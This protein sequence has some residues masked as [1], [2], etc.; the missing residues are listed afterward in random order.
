MK[1]F[2]RSSPQARKEQRARFLYRSIEDDST[3]MCTVEDYVLADVKD[4]LNFK[5]GVHREGALFE[6]LFFALMAD[7]VKTQ[8]CF[9]C[10]KNSS[11]KPSNQVVIEN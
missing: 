5:F 6:T 10:V 3:I 1:I 4:R 7:I 9:M 8:N 2:A 11:E